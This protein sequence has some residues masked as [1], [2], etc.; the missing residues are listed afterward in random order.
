MLSWPYS[1]APK[2]TEAV[3]GSPPAGRQS[4]WAASGG[5][6]TGPARAHPRQW[7]PRRVMNAALRNLPI[8][9][10]ALLLLGTLLPGC[11][12]PQSTPAPSKPAEA[13]PAEWTVIVA[14]ATG[15]ADPFTEYG[16]NSQY[17]L[18]PHVVEPLMHAELLPDGKAWG[19]VN[20]LAESWS[21]PDPTTLRVELKRGVRFHNGEE[22]TAEHVKYAYDSIVFAPQPGRRANTLKAL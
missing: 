5:H 20:D 6:R 22:V 18:I 2:A 7:C 16:T 10:A 12:S 4:V 8:A 19:I 21:F 11:R 9:M 1:S 17:A 14:E 3:G 15:G 13:R